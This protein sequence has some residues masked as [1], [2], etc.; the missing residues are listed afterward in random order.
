MRDQF[1]FIG[2]KTPERMALTKP[3]L[4][5]LRGLSEEQLEYTVKELWQLPQREFQ[6]VAISLVEQHKKQSNEAHIVLLE[7]LI[8]G[9]S[10]WDTVDTIASH[11]I[12]AFFKR[13]PELASAYTQKW[14]Q[15]DNIWLQRTAILYQLT[16]KWQTDTKRLFSYI[17]ICKESGEFFIRKA[18]G[19]ALREYSTTD[20]QAVI[21]FLH[22]HTLSPLSTR[23]AMKVINRSSKGS[24]E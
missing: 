24:G 2:L 21:T 10:W 4:K 14:I 11:L 6:Y 12:G 23:E 16:Y 3:W 5:E 1:E 15:S 18:I 13:Y 17:L 22:N 7:S 20:P 8:T 9:K 19:W